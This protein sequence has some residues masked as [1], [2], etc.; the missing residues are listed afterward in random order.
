M[1]PGLRVP[2][3]VRIPR[4]VGWPPRLPGLSLD[5]LAQRLTFVQYLKDTNLLAH[6]LRIWTLRLIDITG[7]GEGLHPTSL[8]R[9]AVHSTRPRRS[10]FHL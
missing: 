6:T 3:L 10:T 4:R 2:P 7:L 9:S 5:T 1:W 8:T